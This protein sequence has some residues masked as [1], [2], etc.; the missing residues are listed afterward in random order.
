M[1]L[2]SAYVCLSGDV[3]DSHPNIR[4]DDI[5]ELKEAKRLLEEAVVLPLWMPEYF[6]VISLFISACVSFR[7]LVNAGHF[8][9]AL[10]SKF[11][12][13]SAA[14]ERRID[15]WAAGNWKNHAGKGNYQ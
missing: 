13:D 14:V 4:W 3:M 7:E 8:M 2:E 10:V 1:C 5:A 11:K 12:G 6:K 9:V 15:V